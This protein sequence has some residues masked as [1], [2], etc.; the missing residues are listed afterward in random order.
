MFSHF[1]NLLHDSF[2]PI[3]AA[4][5]NLGMY[6]SEAMQLFKEESE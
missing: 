1:Y 3:I 5:L 6:Q 2:L 4:C